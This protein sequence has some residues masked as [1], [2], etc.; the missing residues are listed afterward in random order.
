MRTDPALKKELPS[1][2]SFN[3]DLPA[4]PILS[5]GIALSIG[6]KT[7]AALGLLIF[8]SLFIIFRRRKR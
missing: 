8:G 1:L 4:N 2:F 7:L 6:N 5:G 3:L